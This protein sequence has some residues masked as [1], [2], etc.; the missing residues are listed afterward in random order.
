VTGEN[1]VL[2]PDLKKA[3][4]GVPG[5]TKTWENFAPAGRVNFAARIS[6]T[7]DVPALKRAFQTL[8]DRHPALRTTFP[9]RTSQ[10]WIDASKCEP[11]EVRNP[12][13]GVSWDSHSAFNIPHSAFA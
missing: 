11:S 2:G 5:L 10:R 3:L 1:I 6:A 9:V 7:L 12:E 8:I 13:C 4:E